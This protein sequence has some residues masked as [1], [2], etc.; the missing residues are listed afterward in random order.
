MLFYVTLRRNGMIRCKHE[1]AV[2]IPPCASRRRSP[3]SR[4]C[5]RVLRGLRG[6]A[7][8]VAEAGDEVGKPVEAEVYLHPRSIMYRGDR[9]S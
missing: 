9:K 3:D 5:P 2:F 4:R 6:S 8:L 7:V 1:G